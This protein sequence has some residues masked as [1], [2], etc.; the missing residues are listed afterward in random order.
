MKEIS[1]KV[2][3]LVDLIKQSDDYQEY[4]SLMN[5]MKEDK[6]IN[7]LIKEIKDSQKKIMKLKSLGEDYSSYDELIK[8]DLDKLETFP[9]YVEF[10]SPRLWLIQS[11]SCP[12]QSRIIERKWNL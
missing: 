11:M 6:D 12:Q 2:G 7:S 3:K 5:I 9:I 8:K 4:I 1:N 10:S